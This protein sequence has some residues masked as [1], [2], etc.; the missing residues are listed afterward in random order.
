MITRRT[1]TTIRPRAGGWGVH[2][3]GRECTVT[4][5]TPNES[6]IRLSREQFVELTWATLARTWPAYVHWSPDQSWAAVHSAI[7]GAVLWC[8]Q[9]QMNIVRTQI[10]DH[11]RDALTRAHEQERRRILRHRLRSTLRRHP[12]N[13]QKRP[14]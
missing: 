8:D 12:A 5:L 2:R 4:S 7:D 13:I 9:A 6:S 1:P 10:I 3:E 11:V 14:P